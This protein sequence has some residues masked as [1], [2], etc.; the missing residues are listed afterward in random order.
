VSFELVHEHHLVDDILRPHKGELGAIY[1]GVHG[2]AMRMVNY[3]R[4]FA[5]VDPAADAAARAEREDLAAVVAACHDLPFF[6]NWNLDYLDPAAD[7]TRKVL[8]DLGHAKLAEEAVAMVANHHAIRPYRGPHADTVEATRRADWIDVSLGRLRFGVPR[9]LV[10]EISAAFPVKAMYP[11]PVCG[12]IARY[13]VRHPLR[14][15][16]MLKW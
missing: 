5:P 10:R 3:L 4:W 12:R 8:C 2:H 16:P 1:P 13:A 11:W 6:A 14:P 7:L 15:L 9:P